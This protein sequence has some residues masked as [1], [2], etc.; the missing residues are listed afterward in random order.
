MV[1]I[2]INIKFTVHNNTENAFY[3]KRRLSYIMDKIELNEIEEKLLQ[4]A[5]TSYLKNKKWCI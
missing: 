1:T 3:Q 5:Y 4:D 2:H